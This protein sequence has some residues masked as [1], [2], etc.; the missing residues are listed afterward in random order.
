MTVDQYGEILVVR[1]EDGVHRLMT[2]DG[3]PLEYEEA[4]RKAQYLLD[5]REAERQGQTKLPL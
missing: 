1:D 2:E 4:P 5:M 3:Q